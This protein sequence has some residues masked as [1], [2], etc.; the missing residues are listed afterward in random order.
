MNETEGTH[1]MEAS[2]P[3]RGRDQAAHT[4]LPEAAQDMDRDPLSRLVREVNDAGVSFGQMAERAAAVGEKG[5]KPYF[6]KLATNSVATAPS[7]DLLRGIAAGLR[8]PL[9]VVQRAAAI[10]FLNYR[11]TELAG[12]DEET[13]IIVAHLAGMEKSER[14]RWLAMIEASERVERN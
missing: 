8:K 3:D 11:A 14:R 10:Q 6:Q 4:P 7:E 1:P 2:A 9:P 5:S 13:R 12:Y